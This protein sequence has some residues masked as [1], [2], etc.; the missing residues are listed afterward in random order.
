MFSNPGSRG[1]KRNFKLSNVFFNAVA[2]IKLR[3]VLESDGTMVHGAQG[4]P[5]AYT[6][7]L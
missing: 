4:V 6:A 2:I 7:A 5:V 3:C 1:G